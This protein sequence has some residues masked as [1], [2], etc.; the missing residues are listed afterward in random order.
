VEA[1]C[2][3]GLGTHRPSEDGNA[4]RSSTRKPIRGRP[5]PVCARTTDRTALPRWDGGPA[6]AVD[7][8]ALVMDAAT[9]AVAAAATATLAQGVG[10]CGKGGPHWPPMRERAW[11]T[12]PA[13]PFRFE[14]PR[15][16][17]AL[18]SVLQE[19][20]SAFVKGLQAEA[21]LCIYHRGERVRPPPH[22]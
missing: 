15:M 9:M 17:P 13:E 21:Q 16:H 5:E 19:F 4:Y 14:V 2:V 6:V 8:E 20:K 7:L 1:V 10:R 12:A 22:A 18:A 3:G 11:G